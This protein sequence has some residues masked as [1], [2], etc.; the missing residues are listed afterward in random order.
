MDNVKFDNKTIN[1]LKSFSLINPSMI[2]KEG[3]VMSTVSPLKNIFARATIP[4]NLEKKFC[5][6]SLSRFLNT[7]SLFNDPSFSI[8]D[9]QLI[10]KD[11][12]TKSVNY[13]LAEEETVP[14]PQT[15]EEIG[16]AHV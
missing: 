4:V 16:R 15:K 12:N 1:I 3:T 10:I 13:L 6:Y 7:L 14:V 2:F 11:G 9:K 5:V 8:G